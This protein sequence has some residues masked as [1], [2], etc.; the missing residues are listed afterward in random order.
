[1]KSILDLHFW[2]VLITANS[3]LS[4][5]LILKNG[6]I[7]NPATQKITNGHLVIQDEIIKLAA[8]NSRKFFYIL[9]RKP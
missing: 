8:S 4:Q 2:V 1:M 7:V 5:N 9:Y 6:H 3:T